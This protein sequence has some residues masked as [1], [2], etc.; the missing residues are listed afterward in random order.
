M[1]S[2]ETL[3]ELAPKLARELGWYIRPRPLKARLLA[4]LTL[5]DHSRRVIIMM[6]PRTD[7][8]MWARALCH[9]LA[10]AVGHNRGVTERLYAT[11]EGE[12]SEERI[13][14]RA[15][16]IFFNALVEDP[17]EQ[18][19]FHNLGELSAFEEGEA[20]WRAWDMY[21]TA[22]ELEWRRWV[23]IPTVECNAAFTVGQT[24]FSPSHLK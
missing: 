18:V 16:Q 4:G 12:L 17:D 3:R 10:H 13:A 19:Q 23:C 15:G 22:L 8:H 5:W 11:A 9:E 14:E 20:G 7:I 21:T 6:D 24:W 1:I 2:I